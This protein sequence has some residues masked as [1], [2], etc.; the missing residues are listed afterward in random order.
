MPTTTIG[1]KKK[2]PPSAVVLRA[3][4]DPLGLGSIARCPRRASARFES[5]NRFSSAIHTWFAHKLQQKWDPLSM[6]KLM[7]ATIRIRGNPGPTGRS[8]RCSAGQPRYEF[9]GGAQGSCMVTPLIML[10]LLVLPNFLLQAVPALRERSAELT[11]T[12]DRCFLS[13]CYR[14][15]RRAFGT[16][17]P[18]SCQPGGR[19]LGDPGNRPAMN[20]FN[21]P[22]N[23]K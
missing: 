19:R 21:G 22:I 23:I 20:R 1:S 17:H 14:K 3:R 9:G 10:S 11:V 7:M 13:V 15:A 12:G 5:L 4:S 6:A 18:D 16:S 2:T 8:R